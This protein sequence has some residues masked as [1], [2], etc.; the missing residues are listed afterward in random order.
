MSRWGKKKEKKNSKNKQRNTSI[1]ILKIANKKRFWTDA[2][3]SIKNWLGESN[4][5]CQ[6]VSPLY[7]GHMYVP[8]TSHMSFVKVAFVLS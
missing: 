5:Y 8:I 1:S 3:L 6:K 4:L 7:D 2:L